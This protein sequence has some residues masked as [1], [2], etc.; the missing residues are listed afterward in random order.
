MLTRSAR[1]AEWFSSG[2]L[3]ISPQMAAHQS[4][5]RRRPSGMVTEHRAFFRLKSGKVFLPSDRH[6]FLLNGSRT[7]NQQ[8]QSPVYP[9]NNGLG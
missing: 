2:G 3:S 1:L 8:P 6:Q 5:A 9:M 7:P 4:G